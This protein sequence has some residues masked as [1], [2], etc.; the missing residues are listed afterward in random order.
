MAQQSAPW[1][2]AVHIS[3]SGNNPWDDVVLKFENRFRV[4]RAIVSLRPQMS[5]RDR[6]DE[7]R[8]D[9]QPGPCLAKASLHHVSRSQFFTGGPNV[10]CFIR[11]SRCGT[12]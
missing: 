8:S 11:V 2:D 3:G 7:L 1:Q 4:E 9:A 6:I 10:D 12:A 5:A